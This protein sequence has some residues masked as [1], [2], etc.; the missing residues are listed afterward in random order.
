M[1]DEDLAHQVRGHSQES[2]PVV[3]FGL[4]LGGEPEISLVHQGG[5]LERVVGPL[6]AQ[7]AGGEAAEFL[8]QERDQEFR[9]FSAFGGSKV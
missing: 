8:I 5:R 4:V 1:V 9:R 6:A 7:A 2:N 3:P